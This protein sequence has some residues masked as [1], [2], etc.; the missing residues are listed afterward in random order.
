M[1]TAYVSLVH[2]ASCSLDARAGLPTPADLR[3]HTA[4][5]TSSSQT[6]LVACCSSSGD[7]WQLLLLLPTMHLP[8]RCRWLLQPGACDLSLHALLAG[9]LCKTLSQTAMN[10]VVQSSGW[11]ERGSLIF[12]LTSCRTLAQPSTQPLVIGVEQCRQRR[13]QQAQPAQA[14]SAAT[15]HRH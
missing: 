14:P 10:I 1:Q 9:R 11:P 2:A 15:L 8:A 6:L 5:A 3:L 12:Q 7:S 13:Q 4:E